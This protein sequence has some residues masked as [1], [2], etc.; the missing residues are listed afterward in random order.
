MR[1]K[2]AKLAQSLSRPCLATPP[3][4]SLLPPFR[5]SLQIQST[6]SSFSNN[7]AI[8]TFDAQPS[9]DLT[10]PTTGIS[11]DA[12]FE[13]LGGPSSLLSVSLS[14]SQNL[15]TRRGTLVGVSGSPENA[16][17][18]LS[19]L[20]PLLRAAFGIPFMYQRVASTTP[21]NLLIATK[22]SHTS[23]S[24]LHMDG[25]VDWTVAQRQGLVAWTGHTLSVKPSA[26]LRMV[27]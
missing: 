27:G 1:Q 18:T 13:V 2:S 22:A 20:S 26:N 19:P 9:R 17:S 23:F 14:A 4:S 16:V 3:P 11:P 15:F 21:L 10:P 7:S 25:R 24:V 8:D 5:R 12:R 6:P